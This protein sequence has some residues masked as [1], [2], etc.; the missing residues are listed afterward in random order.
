M[1]IFTAFVYFSPAFCE[2]LVLDGTSSEKEYYEK[3]GLSLPEWQYIKRSGMPMKKVFKL[4]QAG[5][6][7]TEYSQ[8]PWKEM[9]IS[10]WRWIRK[11]RSGLTDEQ[12]MRGSPGGGTLGRW[13]VLQSFLFPGYT[14]I[15]M[16]QYGRGYSM[17]GIAGIS[18]LMGGISL[19]MELQSMDPAIDYP[20]FF[21][22]CLPVAMGWSGVD[23]F[24]QVEKKMNKEAARFSSASPCCDTRITVHWNIPLTVGKN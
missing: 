20:V 3:L 23:M 14:Q 5:I 21:F 1:P 15:K 11:R 7:I 18:L 4:L 9:N 16:G 17:L 12:I 8:E 10:E 24:V 13:S 2:N 6:S 19:G 22:V